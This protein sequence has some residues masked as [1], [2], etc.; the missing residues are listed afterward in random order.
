MDDEKII[1]LLFERSELAIEALSEKYGKSCERFAMRLL[2][3]SA[4]AEDCMND[5]YFAVWNSIP[6]QRPEHLYGYVC[7]IVRNL[8]LKRRE[9]GGAKKRGGEYDLALDEIEECIPSATTV[10]DEFESAEIARS[11]DRFLAS[12]DQKSRVM[13]VK[14]YWYSASI[15]ELAEQ[16]GTGRHNVTVRLSRIREKLKKHLIK[17][18]IS[19]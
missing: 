14:R 16:F 4:D 5:A 11:I 15:D 13:F 6:P 1:A 19:L 9:A 10:E 2:N 8:A 12:L 7:R 17:E 3:N 18:G